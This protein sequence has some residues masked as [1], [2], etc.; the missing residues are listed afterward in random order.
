MNGL[1]KL[2]WLAAIW[3]LLLGL[4]F[5][6]QATPY[7]DFLNRDAW[8]LDRTP[9]GPITP[10]PGVAITP[11]GWEHFYPINVPSPTAYGA[12]NTL[13]TDVT[14]NSMG[15]VDGKLMQKYTCDGE[16]L[17]LPVNWSLTTQQVCTT[18]PNPNLTT[19]NVLI[20]NTPSNVA[21]DCTVASPLGATCTVPKC[22][23]D[24]VCEQNANCSAK[25]TAATFRE[26]AVAADQIVY[27]G[28]ITAPQPEGCD[29]FGFGSCATGTEGSC[30]TNCGGAAGV[31]C[32]AICGVAKVTKPLNPSLVVGDAC[33]AEAVSRLFMHNWALDNNPALLDNTTNF[34]L[35]LK[36]RDANNFHQW[37]AYNIPFKTNSIGENTPRQVFADL[38]FQ[39]INDYGTVGYG[40]PCP[41]SGTHTYDLT[42]V[43]L[44]T[45]VNNI[46]PARYTAVQL[47]KDILGTDT[48]N[49]EPRQTPNGSKTI[50]F[51]Y[52]RGGDSFDLTNASPITLTAG[53]FTSGGWLP[54]QYTCD[55]PPRGRHRLHPRRRLSSPRRG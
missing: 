16:G 20:P 49:S 4:G 25:V 35:I 6:V 42:L 32:T 41:I 21:C 43:G 55:G 30:C 2:P 53:D 7:D 24:V 40:P 44:R 36:D 38:F 47:E 17:S 29:A 10:P 3:L 9:S 11:N 15:V 19:V 34:A 14:L 18:I 22:S 12:G 33:P 13:V 26:Q 50:S 8:W 48:V 5:Q 45:P 52:T 54:S 46:D 28:C 31:S 1:K 39:A 51:T 37:A 23:Y 27:E